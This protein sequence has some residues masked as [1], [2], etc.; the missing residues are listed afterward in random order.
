MEK[1][2]AAQRPGDAP[3]IQS[4]SR[5]L[6][7]LTLLSRGES[8]GFSQ[9]QR[10]CGLSKAATA[11]ILQTLEYEGWVSR[12]MVDGRYR[13]SAQAPI[14]DATRHAQ[15][16]L[17]ELAADPLRQMHM[18]TLWPSDIAVCDG[19]KMVFLES[20]RGAGPFTINRQI[21]GL[22]PRM[23]WSAVGRTYLAFCP[24]QERRLILEN[25]AASDHPDDEKVG[26]TP[27]VRRV[28]KE[29]RTQGYGLRATDYPSPDQVYV[30]QLSAIAVPVR[31]RNRVVACLSLIWILN[32]ATREQIVGSYLALMRKTADAIG[33][34]FERHGFD[35]PP[36]L[37]GR[38]V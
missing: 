23:L 13:L 15:S 20:N 19:A 12:R 30:G 31:A 32:M 5:G 9:L 8:L 37:D 24:P 35:K 2:D 22:H 14:V 29:T 4:L 17:A 38:R 28:I 3:A 36:W 25:L 33:L 7:V 1:H 6:R 34:R 11:R 16:R 18:E 26:D 21:M 27:W 10:E